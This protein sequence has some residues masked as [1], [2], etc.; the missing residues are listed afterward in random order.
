MKETTTLFLGVIIGI[1][2]IL[3]L[4]F[5]FFLTD[6]NNIKRQDKINEEGKATYNETLTIVANI[7]ENPELIK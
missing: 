7:Y 1:V 2:I 6:I 3:I 4:G 5:Y